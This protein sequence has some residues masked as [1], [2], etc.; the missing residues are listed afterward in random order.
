MWEE[1]EGRDVQ[2]DM[3]DFA[4]VAPLRGSC[5][6]DGSS[7]YQ[8]NENED[9]SLTYSFYPNMPQW[10]VGEDLFADFTTAPIPVDDPPV[11]TSSA[12]TNGAWFPRAGG[13]AQIIADWNEVQNWFNDEAGVSNLDVNCRGDAGLAITYYNESYRWM[14]QEVRQERSP[15]K[16]STVLAN[17][18][19]IELGM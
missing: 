2:V 13:G 1:C 15:V 6:G 5:V 11:W 7:S 16:Q 9:G 19:E 12:P 14:Y 3:G 4:G 10:P 8:L 18:Q 17:P